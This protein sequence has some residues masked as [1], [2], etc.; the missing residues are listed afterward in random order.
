MPQLRYE[1][2]APLG[3]TLGYTYGNEFDK[4]AV[5]GVFKL[6]SVNEESKNFKKLLTK[7]IDLFA[8]GE[9]VGQELLKKHYSPDEAALVT[10]NAKPFRITGYHLILTRS[11]SKNQDLIKKFDDG[12]KQL[13]DSG[14]IE[15]V[16]ADMKAGKYK[17]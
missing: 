3:G 9:S 2:L 5:N 15:K 4:A 17:K 8:T 12:F 11:L 16:Y 1:K 10:Y 6:E 14:F 13:Q 7:R